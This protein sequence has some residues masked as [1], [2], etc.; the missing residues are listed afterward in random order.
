MLRF[1]RV[2]TI[3]FIEIRQRSGSVFCIR[4]Q[5]VYLAKYSITRTHDRGRLTYHIS[6]NTCAKRGRRK[7]TLI[8]QQSEL[9]NTT[10]L[11]AESLIE[12]GSVVSEIWPGQVKSG[13]GGRVHLGW[14]IYS[15]K[16]G[17]L[18]WGRWQWWWWSQVTRQPLMSCPAWFSVQP[19]HHHAGLFMHGASFQSSETP[20]SFTT[21]EQIDF[22]NSS[23]ITFTL[24]QRPHPL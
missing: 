21:P 2:Y 6:P 5:R 9:L 3:I 7:Q 19:C 8:L 13:G 10:T 1:S 16:Y 20:Q 15:A 18:Q 11:S 17:N 12:I 24:P 4:T 22:V 14:H 23:V